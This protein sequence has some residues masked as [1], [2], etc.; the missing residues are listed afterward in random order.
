MN[1]T[2]NKPQNKTVNIKLHN[3]LT[4]PKQTE[5]E[6]DCR[7]RNDTASTLNFRSHFRLFVAMVVVPCAIGRS[8][9]F[10]RKAFCSKGWPPSSQ[11]M[12]ISTNGQQESTQS[13]VPLTSRMCPRASRCLFPNKQ[14]SRIDTQLRWVGRAFQ[15]TLS[16][17]ASRNIH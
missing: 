2:P 3:M 15:M 16:A 11:R 9:N 10:T 14:E 12:V 17:R 5:C 7:K 4:S 6:H 1:F 13:C 8:S